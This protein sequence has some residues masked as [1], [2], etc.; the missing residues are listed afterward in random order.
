MREMLRKWAKKSNYQPN[1]IIDLFDE[2]VYPCFAI[3]DHGNSKVFGRVTEDTI[4]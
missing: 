3:G 2:L 4:E 1:G